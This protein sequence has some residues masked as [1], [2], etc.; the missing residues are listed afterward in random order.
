VVEE[1]KTYA[2]PEELSFEEARPWWMEKSPAI[3]VVAVEEDVVLGSA[4][5]GPNLLSSRLAN[6]SNVQTL[7]RTSVH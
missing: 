5:M 2:F 4:K 6:H 7:Q 1:G 3:T